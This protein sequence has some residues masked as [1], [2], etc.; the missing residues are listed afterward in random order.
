[1]MMELH[2]PEF[3]ATFMGLGDMG[4]ETIVWIQPNGQVDVV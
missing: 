1:M 2:G 3:Q 4:G